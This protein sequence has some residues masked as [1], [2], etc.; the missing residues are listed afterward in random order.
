MI[1][2][3]RSRVLAVA[4]CLVLN[5]GVHAQSDSTVKPERPSGTLTT[6]PRAPPPPERTD[7]LI[8]PPRSP[9]PRT[10]TPTLRTPPPD[11]RTAAPPDTAEEPATEPAPSPT[12]PAHTGPAGLSVSEAPAARAAA[13]VRRE[14]LIASKD[15]GEADEQRAWMQS[16]GAAL[17]RR[18]TLSNLGWVITVYRL[19]PGAVPATVIAETLQ[20]W[21]DAM[22]EMNAVY[23]ALSAASTDAPVEYAHQLI[24]WPEGGCERKPRIAMLD[25]PVNVALAAFAGRRLESQVFTPPGSAPDYHH[26]TAVAAVIIGRDT[27]RGLL[28]NADLMVGVIM[29]ANDRKP[30]TST[31]WVLRGLDWVLGATPAPV[32]LNLSFGGPRSAQIARAID[33]VL[34]RTHVVAAAGNDGGDA[35]VFPASH[36]GVIGVSALDARLRRWPDSNTGEHVAISAPGV[37]VWTID[38]SGQGFYASGTSFAAAFVTAALAVTAPQRPQLPQWLE[39]HTR[40]LGAKRRDPQFGHGVL[41]ITNA[42]P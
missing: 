2:A 5:A 12:P 23:P 15:I 17:I 31:E 1:D 28:P 18:R 33:R 34:P 42:C 16:Q 11:R 25:G 40:D 4:A 8:T 20:Q 6:P 9:P 26:G 35:P 3:A 22:P 39:Q 7:D 37:D 30:Y 29:V 27:P 14:L 38:G 32:V 10:A 36:P 24:G 21:P 19:A 41:T 13:A